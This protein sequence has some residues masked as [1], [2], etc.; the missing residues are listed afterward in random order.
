MKINLVQKEQN[1][2]GLS[3]TRNRKTVEVQTRR[4]WKM[5]FKS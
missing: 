4:Q 3:F 1:G 2:Y 5:A